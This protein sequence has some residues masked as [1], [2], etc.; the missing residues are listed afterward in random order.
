MRTKPQSTHAAPDVGGN[1]FG[2]KGVSDQA[3]SLAETLLTG[4]PL[5]KPNVQKVPKLKARPK[6]Q[7]GRKAVPDSADGKCGWRGW[8]K[9]GVAVVF[10]AALCTQLVIAY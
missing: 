5:A 3:E 8:S 9:L 1:G 10:L 6:P 7:F 2:A 4:K